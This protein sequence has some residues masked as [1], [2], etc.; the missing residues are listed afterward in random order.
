MSL[1]NRIKRGHVQYNSQYPWNIV[2]HPLLPADTLKSLG[3]LYG[4]VVDISKHRKCFLLIDSLKLP[5][6]EWHHWSMLPCDVAFGCISLGKGLIPEKC[7][8]VAGDFS[9][10]KSTKCNTFTMHCSIALWGWKTWNRSLKP[11]MLLK[12]ISRSIN[13]GYSALILLS[14]D[15]LLLMRQT[16]KLDWAHPL[17]LFFASRLW[18]WAL[19]AWDVLLFCIVG[20][21]AVPCVP[22]DVEQ[23]QGP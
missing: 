22:G 10:A 16:G 19:W 17:H 20:W 8:R 5:Y 6:T 11:C 14:F 9:H 4:F 3:P 18:V 12:K 2:Q 15:I 23:R 21:N 1:V 13:Y 7:L